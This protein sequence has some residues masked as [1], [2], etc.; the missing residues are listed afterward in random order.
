MPTASGPLLALIGSVCLSGEGISG[1][2]S[3]T[4]AR[5][6]QH[7]TKTQRYQ[8]DDVSKKDTKTGA[9]AS[10]PGPPRTKKRDQMDEKSFEGTDQT[11][12]PIARALN[13]PHGQHQPG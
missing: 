4:P 12:Y 3:H 5:L 6:P 13:K 7:C 9:E 8:K 2:E 1:G 11:R 10:Y